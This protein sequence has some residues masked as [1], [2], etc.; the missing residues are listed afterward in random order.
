[1]ANLG[2]CEP[3]P[4]VLRGQL[5]IQQAEEMHEALLRALE[6]AQWLEVD[7]AEAREVGLSCLQLLC[8]AHRSAR[9]QGKRLTLGSGS[10]SD[11]REAVARA[12]FLRQGGCDGPGD[13]DCLWNMEGEQ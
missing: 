2:E 8:A 5:G 3:M 12:G 11:F 9:R 10:S 7:L 6:Q 1:M 4:L 13:T